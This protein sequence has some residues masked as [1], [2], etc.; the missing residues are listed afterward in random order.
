MRLAVTVQSRCL[1]ILAHPDRPHFMA[2]E[3]ARPLPEIDER[4]PA[5]RTAHLPQRRGHVAIVLHIEIAKTEVY[6]RSWNSERVRA[7]RIHCHT[8]LPLRQHLPPSPER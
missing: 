8:I 5:Q 1:S 2:R 3:P 4:R 7:A 6:H